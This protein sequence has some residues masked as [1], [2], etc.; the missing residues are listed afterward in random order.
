MK[1]HRVM[2]AQ[3]KPKSPQKL[4]ESQLVLASATSTI[5]A[6][7][8]EPPKRQATRV[9][10]DNVPWCLAPTAVIKNLDLRVDQ[11][12]QPN[13]LR[14]RMMEVEK[15]LGMEVALRLLGYRSRSRQEVID[16]LVRKKFSREA[17]EW[18]VNKLCDAGYLNESAFIRA[19]IRE[20]MEL[21]GY[22]R[23]RI[24]S[25]LISKGVEVNTINDELDTLYPTER[26]GKTAHD[27]IQSR[28]ERYA[29]LEEKVTRRRLTQFLLRRGFSVSTAQKVIR[30][31]LPIQ[32]T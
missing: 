20:R 25:E 17:S 13:I 3:K 18:I 29:G 21:K 11:D 7:E 19:W 1:A 32:I 5:T 27:I 26:E 28:L 4:A 30:E 23:Q 2:K 12:Y 15:Q 6:L 16:R 8:L 24:R 14:D 22:G 31:L 9:Y 10:F